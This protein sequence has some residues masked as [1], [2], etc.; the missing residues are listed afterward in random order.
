MEST[1]KLKNLRLVK[2][3]T[4]ILMLTILG[5]SVFSNNIYAATKPVPNMPINVTEILQSGQPYKYPVKLL[6]KPSGLMKDNLFIYYF[7][8]SY[9]TSS[10]LYRARQ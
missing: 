5:I 10:K 6:G 2:I 3:I 8:H 4:W 1:L 9:K 7:I